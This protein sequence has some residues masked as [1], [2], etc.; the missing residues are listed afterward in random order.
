M[1]L[2]KVTDVVKRALSFTPYRVTRSAPNRF[3]GIEHCLARL[4]VHGFEPGQVIDGGAHHGA[5]ALA[6]HGLFPRARVAM[7]EPQPA[8]R[9]ALEALAA[10]HGFAFHPYALSDRP[11]TVRM[12]CG[13]APDTGAHLAW[14]NQ[15]AQPRDVVETVTAKTLDELF[16][17]GGDGAERTLLKLDLQGHELLALRG[18]IR[19]LQHVEVV[20]T[21]VSFYQVAGAPKASEMIGFFDT[22]G[23]DLF[24]VAAL[25]G[26]GRDDRLRQGDLVFV[27]RGSPLLADTAWA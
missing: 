9:A 2:P 13:T 1:R 17:S 26:R 18:A 14:P 16:A 3:E 20:I 23:F 12:I 8:C 24:D 25:A 5:F 21:E 22:S 19:T 11:G 10:L 4:V 27:K 7:I 6:A 15:V